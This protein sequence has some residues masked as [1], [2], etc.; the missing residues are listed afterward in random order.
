MDFPY[1]LS[2]GSPEEGRLRRV[3]SG[4]LEIAQ[5]DTNESKPLLGAQ[6]YS[7]AQYKS[8]VGQFLATRGRRSRC[9]AASENLELAGLDFEDYCAC[10][11][12][13]LARS[14]P[15]FFRQTPDHGLSFR[16]RRKWIWWACPVQL[17]WRRYRGQVHASADQT[18]RIAVR[19]T[20]SPGFAGLQL[21]GFPASQ[22]F[23]P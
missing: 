14:G 15:D 10:Y 18:G 8:D 4:F 20:I 3:I 22:V 11:A 12:R 7:L 13:F 19:A 16:D 17:R 21:S 9:M 23:L 2:A 6:V 1:S 5:A